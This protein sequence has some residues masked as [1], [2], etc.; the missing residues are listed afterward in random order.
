M[1]REAEVRGDVA[2]QEE[3]EEEVAVVEVALGAGINPDLGQAGIVFAQ[4]VDT[5]NHM[6]L[7]N[8]VLTALVPNVAQR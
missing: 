8:A 2:R 5:K 6:S 7:G 4:V 1:A 3:V